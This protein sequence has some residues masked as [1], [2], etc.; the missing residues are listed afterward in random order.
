MRTMHD[1]TVDDLLGADHPLAQANAL[2]HALIVQSGAVSTFAALSGVAWLAD[3][4]GPHPFL[5]A[6]S[7]LAQVLLAIALVLTVEAK[8]DAILSLI[9]GG[10][11]DLPLEAIARGRRRLLR[12]EQRQRLAR[13][14]DELRCEAARPLSTPRSLCSPRVVRSVDVELAQIAHLLR[15]QPGTAQGAALAQL[16]L[17]AP[18]SP[19]YGD[20]AEQL[21]RDLGRLT[22]V[23]RSADPQ[24]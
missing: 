21:R 15:S 24:A 5:L 16:L 9:A 23:L 13:S 10:R 6:A 1:A 20:D 4:D 11:G 18:S 7:A 14:L 12:A 3:P 17:S 22:F 8:R 2:L 19:L